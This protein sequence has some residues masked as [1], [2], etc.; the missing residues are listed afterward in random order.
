MSPGTVVAEAIGTAL[1]Q[2]TMFAI[3]MILVAALVVAIA[4]GLRALGGRQAAG[5]RDRAADHEAIHRRALTRRMLRTGP[6]TPSAVPF[7]SI[8]SGADQS[9]PV[10]PRVPVHSGHLALDG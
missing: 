1:R 8:G 6:G 4:T 10:S 5:F 7:A 3:W 9:A 2:V